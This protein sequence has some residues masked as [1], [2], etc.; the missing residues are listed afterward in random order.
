MA[1][2]HKRLVIAI[3]GPAG[4]GK[5]TVSKLVAKRL[6]LVYIDTGA[7]YRALTLKAVRSGIDL[8]DEGALVELAR[9]TDVD[10]K[11]DNGRQVVLLDSEDV[12][13]LIRTAELTKKVKYIARVPG[14]RHEMVRMQRRMGERS[15]AVMEGR[16]ITT[17]VF[18]DA[19][20]KFYLDAD[21]EERTLRRFK[22]LKGSGSS[23]TLDE[24]RR[25]VAS[26]DDSDMRR[27]VGALKIADDA[28][29]V[30][31]THLSIDGVVEKVLSYI[32]ASG[33]R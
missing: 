26:R 27:E 11:Y 15:G 22:E 20:H 28:V 16:D 25:D 24:I 21:P 23:V 7:M 12:A 8:E 6:G 31:T 3:D 17:V 33:D 18:P 29:V 30:D 5:S 32:S 13:G 4:S 10:L 9:S 2:N 14:V 19:D 1:G